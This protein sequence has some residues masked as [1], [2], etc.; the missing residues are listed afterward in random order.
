MTSMPL[1]TD[2]DTPKKPVIPVEWEL[3]INDISWSEPITCSEINT[4][5]R[6]FGDFNPIHM[7]KNAAKEMFGIE[8]TGRVAHGNLVLGF[9]SG[10]VGKKYPGL[11][12]HTIESIRISSCFCVGDR[13]GVLIREK[14]STVRSGMHMVHIE[15]FL[16]RERK[17]TLIR[18]PKHVPIKI[19]LQGTS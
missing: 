17:K 12:V 9:L 4:A 7:S 5:A 10:I 15:V 16:F 1:G 13:I 19:R 2:S 11:L 8:A 18:V 6:L 3:T 14:S